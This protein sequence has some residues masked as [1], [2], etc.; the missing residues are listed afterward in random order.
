MDPGDGLQKF[1]VWGREAG[2]ARR[3]ELGSERAASQPSKRWITG[4]GVLRLAP[5]SV[6]AW[7][8]CGVASQSSQSVLGDPG[9]NLA[10]RE[11]AS[12]YRNRPPAVWGA[13]S[14]VQVRLRGTTADFKGCWRA[15]GRGREQ[16]RAKGSAVLGH[17]QRRMQAIYDQQAG[18]GIEGRG[19]Q[20]KKVGLGS[21]DGTNRLAWGT[22]AGSEGTLMLD[23]PTA[24]AH[25][26]KLM[27]P[28]PF[29]SPLP[30]RDEEM[31]ART[32]DMQLWLANR[33]PA[34]PQRECN[35]SRSRCSVCIPCMRLRMRQVR[36]GNWWGPGGGPLLQAEAS[37][38][39]SS[40]GGQPGQQGMTSCHVPPS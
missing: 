25:N 31:R 1:D 15:G 27:A 12:R 16:R 28:P 32:E 21:A 11:H 36:Q 29:S 10:A 20:G 19:E 14:R 7:L 33:R 9:A 5:T 38:T 40:R 23:G 13:G 26:M 4:D 35:P 22:L 3:G 2:E 18:R 34:V 17:P 39:A 37:H 6:F 8:N 30:P 24:F